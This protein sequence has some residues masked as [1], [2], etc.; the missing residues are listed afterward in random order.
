MLEVLVP[1]KGSE[2]RSV[3]ASLLAFGGFLACLVF[4]GFCCITPIS[5]FIS[6]WHSPCVCIF[7]S[8]FSLFI[9]IR[10][11]VKLDWGVL[12]YSSMISF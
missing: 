9:D 7:V 5:A 12:P 6:T 4:F 8:K 1:S 10:I 3:P 11:P 2:E